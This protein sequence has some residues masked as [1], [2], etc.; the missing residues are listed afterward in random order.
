MFEQLTTKFEDL[1]Y[2]INVFPIT[3]PPLRERKEDLP[4]L[5]DY[6]LER[7]G[8]KYDKHIS[9]IHPTVLEA[10]MAYDWPGNIRELENVIERAIILE[11]SAQAVLYADSSIDI[12]DDVVKAFDNKS[13]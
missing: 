13:D 12:T 7:V 5:V 8:L 10:F 1:F 2:R 3:I 4:H 9:R 6:I 11:K